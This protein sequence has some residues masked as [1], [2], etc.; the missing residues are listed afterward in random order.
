[1]A[2]IQVLELRPVEDKVEELSYDMTGNIF[3][4]QTGTE[5]TPQG[6][7]IL[8]FG[9]ILRAGGVEAFFRGLFD[10]LGLEELFR[11]A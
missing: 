8:I 7:E 1:M 6:D 11:D 2:S 9:A 5:P 10:A 4:G 3:G